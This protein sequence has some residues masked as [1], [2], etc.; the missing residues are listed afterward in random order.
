MM[1]RRRN[2][3]AAVVVISLSIVGLRFFQ[4][5]I[6]DHYQYVTYAEDNSIREVRLPAP[7]GM[8]FDR[9]GNF[10]VTNR[11]QYSLAVIPAEVRKSMGDLNGLSRYLEIT[12]ADIEQIVD[13]AS[14]PYQKFQ[15]VILF[16]EVSFTQRSYI[17]EHRLEFPGIFFID[18]AIRHYPSR[19][20]ATHIIGYLRN[21]SEDDI[22]EYRRDGYFMGDVVGSAGLEKQS[23]RIL[24]G[25]DGYR[26]H[27]VDYLLRDLGE[28]P[29]KPTRHP[30]PGHDLQLALDIELQAVVEQVMESHRG[31]CIAMDPSNG[32]IFAY[33][34]SPDYVLAPFTG[35]I[36]P[37]LWEQWRDH[38]DKILLDRAINGLYPPGSLFKLVAVAAALAG[39]K[40]DPEET[41]ECKNV[42]VF[43]N[44]VFHCN[45]WPGHGH[46]N[47]EDAVRLSCN[48]YFYKL[49]Q[50]I[51]F[52]AWVEMAHAFGFGSRTGVELPLESVGLVPTPEYMDREYAEQG[53]T[54]GHL[55]NLVLGQ[56][57]LLVTPLQIARM[58]AAIANGGLLVTPKL[59]K[60]PRL[61][62][63]RDRVIDLPLRIW[64]DLQ[65]AMYQVV[66]GEKGTGFRARVDGA[67]IYG[68]TGTAQ[69]PHGD[70][71][72]WFSGFVNTES[73]QQL[74]VTVLVEQ[75]GL[76]SRTAAPI[77][78]QIFQDFI[79][80][81]GDGRED[82]AQIP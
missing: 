27:L 39:G 82:I 12:S 36:P 49:I 37:A 75:G 23:E 44:R 81:Y 3:L 64:R 35:P 30:V 13:E 76:G 40:V 4:Y 42:Y 47:M 73:Y 26:Y 34:S 33:V 63:S 70:S 48:I 67:A 45:I 6:L 5:Q 8:M 28:V 19:A 54:A 24:R 80:R 15:P 43:G 62:E 2:L 52:E 41:V 65:Q 31:V 32:E 78:G 50:W 57:D 20:R 59:V 21:I 66:N 51:G 22:E 9:H 29:H 11:P 53:W 16:E 18:H 38:P 10:L 68:K 56:G 72:S 69:N 14:G 71:H 25:Q 79:Q 46:V 7:R 61:Q 1:I 74:V 17:E 60:S 58:T 55:L 77:G